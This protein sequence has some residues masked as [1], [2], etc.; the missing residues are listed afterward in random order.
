M[1][2]FWINLYFFFILASLYGYQT[3]H[4]R[5]QPAI[6]SGTSRMPKT[7]TVSA[8]RFFCIFCPKGFHQKTHLKNHI[9]VHTGER[10]FKCEIC[11]RCFKRSDSLK[12]H[13]LTSHEAYF[14]SNF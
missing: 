2:I 13:K 12:Y 3:S 6:F 8:P 1:L 4:G 10:P 11:F 9:R 14:K 7:K 5:S